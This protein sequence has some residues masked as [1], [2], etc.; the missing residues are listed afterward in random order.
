MSNKMDKA[1]ILSLRRGAFLE[2]AATIAA[3]KKMVE[4]LCGADECAM[5]GMGYA[6]NIINGMIRQDT[7]L[8]AEMMA[9]SVSG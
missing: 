1:A 7:E 6:I 8:I 4:E 3:R 5:R 2:A 9:T